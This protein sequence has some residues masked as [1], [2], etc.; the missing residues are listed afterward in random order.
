MLGGLTLAGEDVDGHS[1]VRQAEVTEEDP[2]LEAVRRGA[3]VVEL[4]DRFKRAARR[5]REALG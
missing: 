1:L 2:N 4:H 5:K 3:V